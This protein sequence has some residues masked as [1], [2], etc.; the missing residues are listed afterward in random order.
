MCFAAGTVDSGSV[1]T[2]MVSCMALLVGMHAL[3]GLLVCRLLGIT[4]DIPR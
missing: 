4:Q 2:D 3:L 1:P